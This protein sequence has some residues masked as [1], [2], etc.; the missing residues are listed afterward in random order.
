MEALSINVVT[1]L[2]GIG[3]FTNENSDQK[4]ESFAVCIT[5]CI[6]LFNVLFMLDVIRTLFIHSQYCKCCHDWDDMDLFSTND[7]DIIEDEVGNTVIVPVESH[8][9]IY[10]AIRLQNN[11]RDALNKRLNEDKTNTTQK[12]SFSRIKSVRTR[13]VETIQRNSTQNRNSYVEKIKKRQSIHR[14][15]L[16]QKVEARKKAKQLNAMNKLKQVAEEQ[17]AE[18]QVAEEREKENDASA[19]DCICRQMASL[20]EHLDEDELLEELLGDN[21]DKDLIEKIRIKVVSSDK[22]LIEKIEKIRIKVVSRVKNEKR[23]TKI[24]DRIDLDKSNSIDQKEFHALLTAALG[25]TTEDVLFGKIWNV[26]LSTG[27][28][29][30]ERKNDS[31]TRI[32]KVDLLGLKRWLFGNK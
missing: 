9:H 19:K 13:R 28:E 12:N 6:L 20:Q 26:V 25:A 2:L 7:T 21:G 17:V 24:F 5:V 29:D 8:A 14:D 1:L 32:P 4:S 31:T 16:H 27:N 22:D 23:L 11:V 18:E 3:L 30:G 10:A 15:S